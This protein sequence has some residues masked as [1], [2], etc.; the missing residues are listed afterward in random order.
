MAG[1]SNL[2]GK[3]MKTAIGVLVFVWAVLAL[4]VY[5]GGA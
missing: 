4:G 1:A 2:R 5:L 3:P